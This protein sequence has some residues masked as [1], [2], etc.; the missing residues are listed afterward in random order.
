VE[1]KE[2]AGSE[3]KIVAEGELLGA[4]REFVGK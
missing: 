4:V 3:A 2:C 1:W